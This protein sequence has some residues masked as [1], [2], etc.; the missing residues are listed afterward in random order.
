MIYKHSSEKRIQRSVP[1]ASP[2]CLEFKAVPHML[3]IFRTS[4]S[5]LELAFHY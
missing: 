5:I 2:R 1:G 3:A 4:D